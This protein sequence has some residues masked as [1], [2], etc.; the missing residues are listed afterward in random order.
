MK[1]HVHLHDIFSSWTIIYLY[2]EKFKQLFANRD[3]QTRQWRIEY[4]V[5]PS[6]GI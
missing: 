3:F 6:L 5:Y 2:K 4:S 1:M